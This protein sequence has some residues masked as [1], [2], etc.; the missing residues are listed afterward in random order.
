MNEPYNELCM[1]GILKLEQKHLETNG[2]TYILHMLKDFQVK[3]IIFILLHVHNEQ[4][5]LGHPILR[6]KKMIH[7]ITRF[8]MLNKE[9]TTKTLGRAKLTKITLAKWDGRGMKLSAVN[10]MELNLGMHLI[11]HKIYSS[12]W[13]NNV[14]Y[15]IVDLS[16]KV[17]E[18]NLSF[19]LTKM[20]LNQL[21][22]NMERI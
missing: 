7:K 2:L 18:N 10:D 3:W 20:L 8:P 17:V 15:K 4:L 6:T 5:W 13:L 22:K 9:K 16:Y 21:N 11:S 12:S 14:S 19:N 1:D